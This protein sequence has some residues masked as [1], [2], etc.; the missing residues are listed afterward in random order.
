MQTCL[1]ISYSMRSLITLVSEL[2]AQANCWL[3]GKLNASDLNSVISCE[4]IHYSKNFEHNELTAHETSHCIQLYSHCRLHG[5]DTYFNIPGSEITTITRSIHELWLGLKAPNQTL[6][7]AILTWLIRWIILF[8]L[9]ETFV[10]I[11]TGLYKVHLNYKIHKWLY[12][13]CISTKL[14]ICSLDSCKI[15]TLRK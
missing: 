6:S 2:S 7:S 4:V 15:Y 5:T 12:F 9:C 11:V 14:K 1:F 13:R 8:L 10:I 3:T